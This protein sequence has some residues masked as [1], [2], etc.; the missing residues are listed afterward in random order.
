M[1]ALLDIKVFYHI[2]EKEA[3]LKNN[4]RHIDEIKEAVETTSR[5]L[6]PA[7]A[8]FTVAS[9]LDASYIVLRRSE[10]PKVHTNAHGSFIA[11]TTLVLKESDPESLISSAKEMLALASKLVEVKE[12]EAKKEAALKSQ[13]DRI[14]RRLY[15]S[16][17][18]SAGYDQSLQCVKTAIDEIVKLEKEIDMKKNRL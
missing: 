18:D 14:Y 7:I 1:K 16:L 15:P 10:L 6:S 17:S 5:S 8:A 9:R 3:S 11:G 2:K 4:K 12:E 13:R